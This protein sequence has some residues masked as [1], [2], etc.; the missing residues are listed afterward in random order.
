MAVRRA[1][2]YSTGFAENLVSLRSRREHKAWGVS[3]RFLTP[4]NFK[5]AERATEAM[6]QNGWVCTQT[7]AAHFHGLALQIIYQSLGLTPQAL[8]L[9]LL[10]RLN[11]WAEISE[12]L[13][14]FQTEPERL[15][16]INFFKQK[17][18][19]AKL[20]LVYFRKRK[21]RKG[22]TMGGPGFRPV[23]DERP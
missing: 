6:Q 15:A 14:C 18:E 12:R 22:I 5:P 7:A 23:H 3:P 1:L 17:R 11:R 9:R 20:L 13:Q 10:R 16:G 4:E 2:I 19:L 8:R 21:I